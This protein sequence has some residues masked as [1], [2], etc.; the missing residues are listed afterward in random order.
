MALESDG[1]E[2]HRRGKTEGNGEPGDATEEVRLDA[3][4]GLG[5]DSTLLGQCQS[6][7]AGPKGRVTYPVSLVIEHGGEVADDLGQS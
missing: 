4:C 5:S 2:T 7:M 1:R 3:R 6:P